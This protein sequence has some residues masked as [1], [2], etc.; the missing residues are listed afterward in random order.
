ML[1]GAAVLT[2]FL[3]LL[4]CLA[5]EVGAQTVSGTLT[6]N[7]KTTTLGF[8]YAVAQP[9][10]SDKSKEDV[11]IILSETALTDAAVLDSAERTTAIML[12]NLKVVQVVLSADRQAIST[13]INDPDLPMSISFAGTP[14]RVEL[15]TF[16]DQLVEGRVFLEKPDTFMK[17][18]YQFSA[19]FRAPI[20]RKAA[21]SSAERTTL[22]EM[23][24][25][26]AAIAYMKAVRAG[27]VAG[28]K[29]AIVPERRADLD[30]PEGKK[31]LAFLK[32]MAP[33]NPTVT[34]VQG[35]SEAAV[36]TLEEKTE[37]GTSTT[38]LSLT[39]LAG[40]WLVSK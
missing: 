25:A 1:S 24:A 11:R 27:N 23:P 32:A 19:T 15:K 21:Q 12:G 33:A 6:V 40:R 13:V 20:R 16:D 18:T 9:G 31:L 22:A 30:G 29:A 35:S 37:N 34:G 8:V 14:Q 4:P 36:V 26:K 2:G 3:C 10:F 28:I 38:K 7:G 39:T 5:A 17:A